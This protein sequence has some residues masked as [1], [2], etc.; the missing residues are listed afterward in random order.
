VR[1]NAEGVCVYAFS[2]GAVVSLLDRDSGFIDERELGEVG[3]EL[4]MEMNYIAAQNG[5]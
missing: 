1:L 4:G 5:G 3:A 2:D